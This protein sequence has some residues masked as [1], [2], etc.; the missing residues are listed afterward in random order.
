MK[1]NTVIV[2]AWLMALTFIVDSALLARNSTAVVREGT[3]ILIE[4]RTK[5]DADKTKRG[6]KFKAWTVESIET[7]ELLPTSPPPL[8]DRPEFVT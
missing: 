8:R 3:R 5:L 7:G 1:R 4:L 6:K 2:A